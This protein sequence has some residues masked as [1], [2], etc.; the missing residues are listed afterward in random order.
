MADLLQDLKRAIETGDSELWSSLHSD[1]FEQ[2]ELWHKTEPPSNPRKRSKA[3]VAEIVGRAVKN[4]VQFRI[5]NM[6]GDGNRLAYTA[7]C[8]LPNGRTVIANNNAEV[9]DGLIV[10]ELV[11]EAGEPD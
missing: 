1:D 6:V 4:G 5:E 2:I 11:V 9:K 10:S 3:E 8:V 7:T